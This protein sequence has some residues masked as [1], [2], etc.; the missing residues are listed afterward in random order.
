MLNSFGECASVGSDDWRAAQLRLN[1]HAAEGLEV[2]GR[3]QQARE[4]AEECAAVGTVQRLLVEQVVGPV[5]VEVLALSADHELRVGEAARYLDDRIESLNSADAPEVSYD[6]S[7]LSHRPLKDVI[8]V[9]AH[10][11]AVMG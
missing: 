5:G 2:C 10:E 9:R 8:V 7:G 1:V 4:A 11:P 3:C 6:G